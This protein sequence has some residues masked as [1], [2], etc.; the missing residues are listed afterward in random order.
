MRRSPLL[1]FWGRLPTGEREPIQGLVH[2]YRASADPGAR[3]RGEF[4]V[5]DLDYL[6]R[7]VLNLGLRPRDT[8][9]GR[10]RSEKDYW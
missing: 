10:T 8:I 9:T 5:V 2:M 3:R 1:Q 7:L 6:L 4:A